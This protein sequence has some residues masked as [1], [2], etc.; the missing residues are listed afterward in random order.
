MRDSKPIAMFLGVA[1]SHFCSEDTYAIDQIIWVDP[2]YRGTGAGRVLV[3]KY[4]EWCLEMGVTLPM[5]GSSTG[6]NIEK[7]KAF[8]ES[9]G[10]ECVGHNFVEKL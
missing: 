8:Y 6:I 1:G 2:E 10:F 7:T 5:I 9:C 4:K 3:E